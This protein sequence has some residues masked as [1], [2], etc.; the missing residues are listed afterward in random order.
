MFFKEKLSY[1]TNILKIAEK[2][3]YRERLLTFNECCLC[4]KFKYLY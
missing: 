4:L 2:T 1:K 3:Q